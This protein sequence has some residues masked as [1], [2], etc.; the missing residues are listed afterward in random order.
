MLM[1]PAALQRSMMVVSLAHLSEPERVS[2]TTAQLPF[3]MPI[4]LA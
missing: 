2:G 3:D 4:T 1:M